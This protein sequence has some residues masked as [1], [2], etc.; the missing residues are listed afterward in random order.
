MKTTEI[1]SNLIFAN[2]SQFLCLKL[3]SRAKKPTRFLMMNIWYAFFKW[4]INLLWSSRFIFF[5]WKGLLVMTADRHSLQP[6][7]FWKVVC[8]FWH[9]ILERNWTKQVAANIPLNYTFKGLSWCLHYF[10][11]ILVEN[12]R[13]STVKHSPKNSLP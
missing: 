7:W 3:F 4:T 11:S 8:I 12:P 13:I 10:T 2:S 9:F 1:A 5:T 6:S